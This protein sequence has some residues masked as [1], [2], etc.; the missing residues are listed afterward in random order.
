MYLSI[1]KMD[2]IYS[3]DVIHAHAFGTPKTV[4]GNVCGVI[5]FNI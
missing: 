1:S 5:Y 4:G 2:I 3:K